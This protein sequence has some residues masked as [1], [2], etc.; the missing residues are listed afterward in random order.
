MLRIELQ[1]IAEEFSNIEFVVVDVDKSEDLMLAECILY[2]AE[3]I[4]T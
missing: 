4:Q 1:R 3:I 2:G